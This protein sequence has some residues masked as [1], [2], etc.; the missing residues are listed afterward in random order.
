MIFKA[1]SFIYL[2]AGLFCVLL[3]IIM[4]F[5]DLRYPNTLSTFLE[6]DP[7]GQYDECVMRKYINNCVIYQL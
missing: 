5:M 3:A 1:S 2:I 4:I 6:I 7:L